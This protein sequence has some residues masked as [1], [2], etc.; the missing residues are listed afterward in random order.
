MENNR[1]NSTVVI[2]ICVVLIVCGNCGIAYKVSL[3]CMLLPVLDKPE[4]A[5]IDRMFFLMLDCPRFF[6]KANVLRNRLY[7]YHV[8]NTS[9]TLSTSIRLRTLDIHPMSAQNRLA[10]TAWC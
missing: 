2:T 1:F 4:R 9:A 3:M 8:E 7:T 6:K 5:V 10:E